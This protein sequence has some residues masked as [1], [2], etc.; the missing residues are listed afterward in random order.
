MDKVSLA[1]ILCF[2]TLLAISYTNG[3][4]INK[5]DTESNNPKKMVKRSKCFD[6]HCIGA[7]HRIFE[8]MN[9]KI[10]PCEDFNQFA[11]GGFIKNKIIPDDKS[12][13]DVFAVLTKEIEYHGRRLLEEPIDD[14]NDFESYKKAKK[15]YKSCMN[16]DKQNELGI[17]PLRKLLN[18]AG[19]WPVVDGD[20]WDGA[21]FNVWDQSIKLNAMGYSSDYFASS[22]ISADAKNN[23][24]RVLHFDQAS[25]GLSKEYFDKGLE[26]PEVKAYFQYMIDVAVLLGAEEKTAKEELQK[27][28]NFEMRLASISAPKT[29]RRNKTKLY[30]PTTLGEFPTLEGQPDSWTTYMQKVFDFGGKR[31]I[32]I[33]DSERVIIYDPNFYKNL[34]SVLNEADKRTKANYAG[35]RMASAT[36]KYLSTEAR[37]IRQK[38]RKAVTGEDFC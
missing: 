30:N 33:E 3:K 29:E 19:G 7:S 1:T 17:E 23:T 14:K 35:W 12:R 32:S 21:N 25:L 6:R 37:E 26:E 22:S 11:C 27:V 20:K 38:Y 8:Y 34:S 16:E 36:M 31:E 28:L 10:D 4:N 18:E 5:R 24:H 15:Y 13:W 9:D 2:L